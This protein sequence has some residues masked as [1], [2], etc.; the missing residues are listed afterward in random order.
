MATKPSSE[1]AIYSAAA[2]EQS[3]AETTAIHLMI[4]CTVSCSPGSA[5]IWL[6]PIEAACSEM[7]TASAKSIL[8]ASSASIISS[9]VIT[10]VTLAGGNFSLAF[11]STITC[12]A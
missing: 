9:R 6:P 5:Q 2:T 11:F 3:F 1:P 12:P 4:S 10:L 7:V 8:P